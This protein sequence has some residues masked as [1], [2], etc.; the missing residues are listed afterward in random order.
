MFVS[1]KIQVNERPAIIVPESAVETI[2][3]KPTVFLFKDNVTLA[4]RTIEIG[5]KIDG[6]VEV[7]SG[8]KEGDKIVSEGSFILKNEVAKAKMDN[9]G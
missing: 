8:L 9:H 7:R 4:A 3:D 1:A 2:D 6:H 5:E